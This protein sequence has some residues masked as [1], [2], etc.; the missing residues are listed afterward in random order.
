MANVKL[1]VVKRKGKLYFTRV[2]GASL[3]TS[4]L[5]RWFLVLS[6]PPPVRFSIM[7]VFVLCRFHVGPTV[8]VHCLYFGNRASSSPLPK[9]CPA[10][11]P[12]SQLSSRHLGFCLGTAYFAS[13]APSVPPRPLPRGLLD[14]RGRRRRGSSTGSA[15]GDVEV[16]SSSSCLSLR[17]FLRWSP[18]ISFSLS[19]SSIHAVCFDVFCGL[20]LGSIFFA[21]CFDVFSRIETRF[22]SFPSSRRRSVEWAGPKLARSL[23]RWGSR[24]LPESSSICWNI[25]SSITLAAS[26]FDFVSP[27]RGSHAGDR[28]CAR[29][30]PELPD[31]LRVCSIFQICAVIVSF[32]WFSYCPLTLYHSQIWGAKGELGLLCFLKGGAQFS[33]CFF[34]FFS[35]LP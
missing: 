25:C 9:R 28:L 19:S 34:D 26:E 13:T 6:L 14:R 1:A 15:V 23:I 31:L 24:L 29:P 27:T 32:V 22:S 7:L 10:I 4:S 12:P 2:R 5:H 30:V 3:S 8:R 33:G 21:V 16:S 20:C 17:S 18:A 35:I 11:S